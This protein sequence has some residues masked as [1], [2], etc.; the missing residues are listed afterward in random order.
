MFYFLL[1][2]Y[3]S[4]QNRDFDPSATH[5]HS[6]HWNKPAPAREEGELAAPAF[7]VSASQQATRY[8]PVSYRHAGEK[9]SSNMNADVSREKGKAMRSSACIHKKRKEV[10]KHELQ[11]RKAVEKTKNQKGQ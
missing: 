7:L 8:I 4:A 3:D 1:P 5:I 11:D 10:R 2:G 6:L 9:S